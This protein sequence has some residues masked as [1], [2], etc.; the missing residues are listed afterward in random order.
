MEP[1]SM[2]MAAIVALLSYLIVQTIYRL[3]FH[4]L[5][6]FPGPKIAAIGRFYEFYFNVIKGGMYIWEIQRMHEKYGPIVRINHRE[7]HI[8]DPHYY[9]EIYSSRKQ[10]KDY[11]AVSAFGMTLSMVTT[12]DHDLHRFRRGILNS[13]FSKRAVVS[14]EPLILEKVRRVAERLEEAF[15]ENAVVPFDKLFAALTADVISK[16]AYGQSL[17]CLESKE[18]KNGFR[19]F[20]NVAG[21]LSHISTFFPNMMAMLKALPEGVLQAMQPQAAGF[22]AVKKLVNDQAIATLSEASQ[23]GYK[24]PEGADKTIFHALC[25]PA[26]PAKEKELNRV[27]EE[28]LAVLGAGTET[29]ARVLTVG[30]FY[31]YHDKSVLYRLR[32]ELKEV[33]P[34]PDSSITW[35]QLEQLPY[36]V[37][38]GSLYDRCHL[39]ISLTESRIQ[40][41][42]VSESLRVSHTLIMRL[43]RIARDHSLA[44]KEFV[45]PPGTPVSQSS[46][47]V[48]TDPTIFPDPEKFDPERWIQA[49]E[50]AYAELYL[51]FAVMARR[52]DMEL[53]ETTIENIRVGRE[54]GIG[55]PKHKNVVQGHARVTHIVAE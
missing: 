11:Y 37:S 20:G 33:M 27:S 21:N 43:P 36:L 40:N 38:F 13:F 42:F 26:V 10:E 28:A 9:D 24:A 2:L 31:L 32:E 15:E 46:Y 48:H 12:L 8:K 25:D 18:L 34:K 55:L 5:S 23:P 39:A 4:P 53:H 44:Y 17:G 52:F 50:K 30:T 1:W 3:Y 45:I 14:L 49:T 51:M 16:Y 41:A 54:F 19:D 22:F 6:K 35:T 7:L 29:T 47:F